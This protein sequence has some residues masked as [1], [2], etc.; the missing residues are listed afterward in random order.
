MISVLISGAMLAFSMPGFPLHI[1]VWF[2]LIPLFEEL[3]KSRPISGGVKGFIFFSTA[4]SIS[5]FWVVGTMTTNFPKF[6]GFSSFE[7]FLAFLLLVAYQ[8]A[9]Y[10][11]FGFFG[12]A[13]SKKNPY[14]VYPSLYA[15]TEILRESGQMGFTGARIS[16]ALFNEPHLVMISSVI[17]DIGLSMIVIWVNVTIWKLIKGRKLCKILIVILILYIPWHFFPD[18][19]RDPQEVRMMK[20]YLYQTNEKPEEKYEES[21]RERLERLPK[22]DDLLITPEAYIASFLKKSPDVDHPVLIGT[23]FFDG[24][25]RYNS[26]LLIDGK[27]AQRYD[28]V[29]LFPFAEFLPYPRFF[30]FLKFLKGFAYYT[31]GRGYHPLNYRGKKIGVLICFE[32]YFDDGAVKYS[33]NSDFIVVMTNDVWFKYKIAL[34]NHFAKAVFRAAESGRWVVQVANKGITGVVDSWGR[35]RLI[36]G[37]GRNILKETWVGRPHPTIYPKIRNLLILIPIVLLILGIFSD[38]QEPYLSNYSALSIL[39]RKPYL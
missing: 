38:Y 3:S 10:F 9:F 19:F 7:G 33:K 36:L 2:S 26:A 35:I 5:H 6:A 27:R 8:G 37:T 18:S 30:G 12:S 32:S 21:V 24:Y 28:K 25:N 29:R 22:T 20:V 17:G 16:D 1:L 13:L 34:W 23:L 31:P 14:L 11:P 39:R 15:L 4:F